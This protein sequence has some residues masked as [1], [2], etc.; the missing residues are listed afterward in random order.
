MLRHVLVLEVPIKLLRYPDLPL[1]LLG[2]DCREWD[3]RAVAGAFGVFGC[4]G[5]LLGK[6]FDT[7]YLRGGVG[8][9]PFADEDVMLDVGRDDVLKVVAFLL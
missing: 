4:G 1:Q 2:K 5:A 9:C 6:P 3:L 7:D 8:A